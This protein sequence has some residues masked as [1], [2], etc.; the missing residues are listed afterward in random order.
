MIE[1]FRDIASSIGNRFVDAWKVAG[2]RVVGYPCTFVPDE[3]MH[4]AGLLPF[5][6]RGITTTT[7]SIGDT[8]FGPVIC[9]YPKCILQLAG[10]GTYSF[11]D[12]AV[13][14]NGCDS[15]RRL[16]ECWRK[17]SEDIPGTRPPFFHYM[18][19]PHKVTPYSV[20]WY[21]EELTGFMKRLQEHFG[22]EITPDRLAQSI[23]L[24]N[25]GRKLL[26]T[27]DDMRASP[28]TPI[29]GADMAAVAIAGSAMPREEYTNS[30]KKLAKSLRKA[31]PVARG[32]IRIMV[33]GS[34][35][36]DLDFFGLIE[37]AGAVVVADTMCFGSRSF[38]DLTD[39]TKD[40][41]SALAQRYLSHKFCPR[42]FGRYK[43]RLAFVL[44]KAE[45]SSCDGVI[46][47]NIRF[48]DL[49]GSENGLFERDLEARGIPCMRI[50]R[51]YGPLMETGRLKMRIDAFF[52]RIARSKRNTA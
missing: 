9:S 50:E 38:H 29:T 3:I 2:G 10:Q 35:C 6:L 25:A 47:Q 4:A 45:Q 42:M 24:Y 11:L 27:I 51:E 48:C 37:Q 41:L 21:E 12:G 19:V 32:K 30:L 52:E 46:L 43:D 1:T 16:D 28:D 20:A 26:V 44:E 49:H 36:D 18:G 17:A 23:A 40:P 22:V 8:Y 34:A 5:R 33:V 39:E 31:R 13:V 14:V 7:L 15:M